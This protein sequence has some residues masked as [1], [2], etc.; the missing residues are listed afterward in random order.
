MSKRLVVR[1]VL[2]VWRAIATQLCEYRGGLTRV[3]K[4]LLQRA[5][6]SRFPPSSQWGV[7]VALAG[8]YTYLF[9]IYTSTH[10]YTHVFMYMYILWDLFIYMYIDR[11]PPTQYVCVYMYVHVYIHRNGYPGERETHELLAARNHLRLALPC[12]PCL[13]VVNALLLAFT[14]MHQQNTSH[15]RMTRE[16]NQENSHGDYYFYFG[17]KIIHF[18]YAF[19]ERKCCNGNF[20]LES[21]CSDAISDFGNL[22]ICV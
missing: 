15:S 2:S 18:Y 14:Y 8:P 11:G 20:F 4:V 12:Q 13:S 3:Q 10:I 9:I 6:T 21:S 5:H 17:T 16:P 19:F 22:R 1:R 7:W